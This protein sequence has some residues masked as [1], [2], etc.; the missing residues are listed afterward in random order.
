M[1]KL[2]ERTITNMEV[3]LDRVCGRFSHGGDHETRKFIAAKLKT[4]AQRGN[5]TLG[6]LNAVADKALKELAK[7]DAKD[8]G[9]RA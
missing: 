4:S 9:A 2:E 7:R 5:T 8:G 3:V 6:A 1:T